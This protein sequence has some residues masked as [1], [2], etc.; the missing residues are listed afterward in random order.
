VDSGGRLVIIEVKL[1]ED[2]NILFQ[3]LRYFNEVDRQRFTIAHLFPDKKIDAAQ[4]PRIILIAERFSEDL[5]RLSTVVKPDIDMFEYSVLNTTDG[6]QGIY[7]HPVH[8]PRIEEIPTKP[9]S[10]DELVNYITKEE[11]KPKFKA[12]IDEVAKIGS[13]ID[14]YHT[15][16]YAGFKYKGRQLAYLQPKR[17]A[18]NFTAV[19]LDED[20]RVIS[21]QTANIESGAEDYSEIL[22]RIRETFGKL[23]GKLRDN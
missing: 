17:R 14:S 8:V 11:L 4:S 20:L 2:E 18:F 23:G 22:G 15:N 7:F 12:I 19:I 5:R 1:T 3:A 10:L 13:G 6:A 16:S 9:I 21:Y